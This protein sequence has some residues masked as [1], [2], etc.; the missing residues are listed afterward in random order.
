MQH[1]M[2]EIAISPTWIHKNAKY[3]CL[4]APLIDKKRIFMVPSI[5]K[6]KRFLSEKTKERRGIYTHYVLSRRRNKTREIFRVTYK[7]CFYERD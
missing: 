1:A 4:L 2:H 7:L 5:H 3:L 6:S